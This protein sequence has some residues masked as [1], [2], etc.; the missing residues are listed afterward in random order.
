M[1]FDWS[2]YAH[3]TPPAKVALT[4][5]DTRLLLSKLDHE[6][7]SVDDIPAPDSLGRRIPSTLDSPRSYA[8][9]QVIVQQHLLHDSL[10]LSE[11]AKLPMTLQAVASGSDPWADYLRGLALEHY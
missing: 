4:A 10:A 6:L 1:R 7:P 5:A 2:A 11:Q 9:T 8:L 3:A